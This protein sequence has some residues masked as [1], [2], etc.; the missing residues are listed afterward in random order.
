MFL[1]SVAKMQEIGNFIDPE[2]VMH[3]LNQG[4]FFSDFLA[5]IA[6]SQDRIFKWNLSSRNVTKL[7]KSTMAADKESAS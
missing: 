1:L 4:Q 2:I 5:C 3:V 7:L 6:C